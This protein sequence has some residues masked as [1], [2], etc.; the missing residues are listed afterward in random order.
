MGSEER[1]EQRQRSFLQS[2]EESGDVGAEGA[3]ME[4]AVRGADG[5]L[6]PLSGFFAGSRIQILLHTEGHHLGGGSGPWVWCG[7]HL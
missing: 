3:G 1:L 2:L 5:T 6:S 7:G 4:R